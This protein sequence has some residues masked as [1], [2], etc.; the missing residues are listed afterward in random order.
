[1]PWPESAWRSKTTVPSPFILS[2]PQCAAATVHCLTRRARPS[3]SGVALPPLPLPPPGC[4]GGT[5]SLAAAA[6]IFTTRLERS[7]AR[8]FEGSG[9]PS[10]GVRPDSRL[11]AAACMAAPQSGGIGRRRRDVRREPTGP[12]CPAAVSPLRTARLAPSW[13]RL[14]SP[15]AFLSSNPSWR[16]DRLQLGDAAA[17]TEGQQRDRLCSQQG[18]SSRGAAQRGAAKGFRHGQPNKL[19]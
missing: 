18:D 14:Y 3:D 13:A 5:A 10:G 17:S 6:A 19:G 12:S 8:L 1:M 15:H 7:A 9:R 11:V 16:C 2:K 4:W